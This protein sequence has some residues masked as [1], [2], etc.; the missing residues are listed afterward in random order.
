MSL[1]IAVD[2][3]FRTI[4]ELTALVNAVAEAPKGTQETRWIEWKRTL[5][6]GTTGARFFVAKAILGFANRSPEVAA[7]TCEGTAYLV[8][9]AE[10]GRVDGV[11]VIDHVDLAQK[12]KRF[13]DRPRWTPHDI[14]YEGK[15]VL[16]IVVA[17]PNN[18]DHI[19]TLQAD[20]DDALAG[21]IFH[22]SSAIT[23]RAGPNDIL[24]LEER[25]LRG[26]L[27]P[28]LDLEL[29]M[30]AAPLSRLDVDQAGVMDWLARREK[31]VRS[32]ATRPERP[33]PSP[34]PPGLAGMPDFA[35]LLTLRRL[36]RRRREKSLIGVSA[37]TFRSVKTVSSIMS[38]GELLGRAETR[39]RSL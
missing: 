10:P 11:T 32:T 17:P 38:F 14:A 28:D 20:Y 30:Q 2:R 25:L 29:S 3:E 37:N 23:E 19:H 24:M 35:G 8:V 4:D 9:G 12:I 39:S 6:L 22:R 7:Q 16:V 15:T 34:R 13:A 21:P 36:R 1:D 26:V 5:D 27:E 33:P 18:G 31:F